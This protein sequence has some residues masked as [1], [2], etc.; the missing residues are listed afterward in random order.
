MF[1]MK[2][3]LYGNQEF[4][5]TGRLKLHTGEVHIWKLRWRELERF[6]EQ[7]ISLLDKEECQKAGRYRFYEDKMRYLAGK[8]VV[9]MLL[10]EY[11]GVDKIVL[12]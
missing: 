6:W 11:S 3:K 1:P 5:H 12:Q 9:K 8:I 7:H 2:I 10:K 4:L